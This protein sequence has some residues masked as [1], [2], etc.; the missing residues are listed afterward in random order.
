MAL[1]N[2]TSLVLFI[3]AGDLTPSLPDPATVSGRVHWIANA[4]LA[5]ITVSS[6]GNPTPFLESGTPTASISI[7]PGQAKFLQADGVSR[8]KILASIGARRIF[9]GTDITDASGNVTFTFTPPFP[10]VPVVS[11]QI[12][13]SADTALVEARVTAVSASSV[14]LNVRRSPSVVILGI[15]V[16]QVPANAVGVTVQ[17][18]AIE[19]GQGM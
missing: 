2:T 17:L 6:T 7:L 11:G 14:T 16:L 4:Q 19:A 18:V 3:E 15:S 12:G 13:P 10:S 8:W 1:R 9:S 5:T